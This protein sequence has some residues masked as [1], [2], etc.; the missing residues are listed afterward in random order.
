MADKKYTP[1]K[2]NPNF[3]VDNT[4]REN[5]IKHT[6]QIS[7]DKSYDSEFVEIIPAISPIFSNVSII[8]AGDVHDGAVGT[9]A[10]RDEKTLEFVK[11]TANCIYVPGGDVFNAIVS[12]DQDKH[13]DKYGI[14]RAI[15]KKRAQFEKIAKKIPFIIDGNHDGQNGK[16][17]V[18]SGMSPAKHL[19]DSLNITHIK[20]GALLELNLPSSDY[21]REQKTIKLF[22]FHCAGRTS[23]TAKSVDN[24]FKMAMAQ[25]QA[26]KIVPDVIFGGHFHSNTN[27]LFPTDVYVYNKSGKLV[28]VKRKDII[29]VSDSTLQENSDYALTAG[30]PPSESNVYINNIRVVKNPYF[31][32]ATKSTQYEY[33]VEMTRIPMFRQN[34]DEYTDEAKEYMKNYMEPEYLKQEVEKE[35]KDL[36]YGK[37]VEKLQN[38]VNDFKSARFLFDE[39][40]ENVSV[41]QETKLNEQ[42]DVIVDESSNDGM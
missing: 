5:E 14:Q 12:P 38:A 23:G 31:T 28:G 39:P 4:K 7:K 36:S 35:Y 22:M 40:R 9:N 32:S 10:V 21:R 42:P 33:M 26:L 1:M 20:Y 18:A 6:I 2:N 37:S 19:A 34:S 15:D 30:F 16:R 29:V 13:A 24:T 3:F 11:N 27:G 41:N 17:W 25:L 8:F